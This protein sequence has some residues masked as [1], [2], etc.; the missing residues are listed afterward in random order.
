MTIH[1]TTRATMHLRTL[2]LAAVLSVGCWQAQA[3]DH[4]LPLPTHNDTRVHAVYQSDRIWNG[5]AIA[6]NKDI[7]FI[8][9]GGDKAGIKAAKQT[10]DGVRTP[11]PDAAWNSWREGDDATHAFVHT[12]AVRIGPD[13]DVW[14]VDSG[15]NGPGHPAVAGAARVFRFDPTSNRLIREYSLSSAVNADSFIDDIRFNGRHAYLTDA[16]SPALLVLDLDSGSVRRVLDHDASTSEGRPVRALH[17]AVVDGK[18]VVHT[19]QVDQLEVT[20]DGQFLY[21]QALSGPLSRIATRWL[22]DPSLSTTQ[23]ASHVEPWFDTFSTGGTAIDADGNLYL[24]DVNNERLIKLTPDRHET[25]LLA[26][27][28][29]QW[30]DAMWLDA[31]GDLYVP[32]TQTNLTPG[33]DHGKLEVHYPVQMLKIHVGE[34][35]AANDHA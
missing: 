33:F 3:A 11:F 16:G 6:A 22:D 34:K 12:N 24:S 8:F 14:L 20:P 7:F 1:R 15:S 10:P 23:L 31:N 26:D 19:V 27:P 13:G 32:S 35:P 30:P 4:D 28:R 9:T 5:M 25:V 18:G 21:Y 29:L 2:T 17:H